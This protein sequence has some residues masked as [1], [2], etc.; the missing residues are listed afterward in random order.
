MF[1]THFEKFSSFDYYVYID[2][3]REFASRTR[4]H[5]PIEWENRMIKSITEVT[6][7]V[8]YQMFE[9]RCK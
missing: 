6:I 2:I 1:E 7:K 5:C 9:Y 8:M 3:A 4:I